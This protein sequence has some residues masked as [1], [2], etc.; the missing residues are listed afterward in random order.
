MFHK[1]SGGY[2]AI[3]NLKKKYLLIAIGYLDQKF[4]LLFSSDL[5][6]ARY[7]LWF[8]WFSPR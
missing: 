6:Y 7:Y 3:S 8:C 4:V 5:G 2:T 1:I